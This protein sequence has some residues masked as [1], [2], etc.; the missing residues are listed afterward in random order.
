MYIISVIE[1]ILLGGQVLCLRVKIS[2]LVSVD[3]KLPG[4][5]NKQTRR[6]LILNNKHRICATNK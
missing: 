2:P 6:V 5:D 1:V 3:S 4:P